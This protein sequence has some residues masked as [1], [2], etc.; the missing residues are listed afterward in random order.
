MQ[1]E[2]RPRALRFFDV[3]IKLLEHRGHKVVTRGHETL[4]IIGEIETQISLRE[5][6]NRVYRTERNWTTSDLVPNG[7]LIF[8]A[9]KYSWDK[10]WRDNKTLLEVML[11]KIVARL[12]LDAK[13]E[14]EW[15]ERS[16]LAEIQRAEEE[17]IRREIEAIRKAGQEKFDL[18]L[19]QAERFDKAQKIRALVAAARANALDDGQISQK[20]KE[21]IEWASRKAD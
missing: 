1:N 9:G 15:R 3:L 16:R 5:A 17:R 12:E 10:E 13:K 7:K 4:V 18:L 14:A 8:K 6:S 2:H 20:R 21:W 19:K 11:A